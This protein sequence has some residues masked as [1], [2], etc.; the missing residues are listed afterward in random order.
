MWSAHAHKFLQ[1]RTESYDTLGL[2]GEDPRWDIFAKFHAYLHVAFPKTFAKAHVTPV[3]TYNLVLH[4]EGSDPSLK[5]I[6][7]TA[8]QD[9]VPVNPETVNEWKYPPYSGYY[10]G[11]YIKQVLHERQLVLMLSAQGNIFMAAVA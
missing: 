3:N 1:C 8:H 5:P 2:V 11:Q 4:L 7:L 6:L 9:V 10:D